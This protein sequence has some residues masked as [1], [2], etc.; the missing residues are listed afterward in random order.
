AIGL[1]CTARGREARP[2]PAPAGGRPHPSPRRHRP[3]S[4]LPPHP[5][6]LRAPDLVVG[7]SGAVRDLAQCAERQGVAGAAVVD[8]GPAAI[9]M[10]VHAARS[11]PGAG[12]DAVA[13]EGR[14][15]LADRNVANLP[16]EP[17]RDHAAS[18][19]TVTTG[20]SM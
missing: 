8:D 19:A 4:R 13:S 2:L 14:N 7:P 6:R 1:R 9:G 5:A 3:A 17:R 20:A 11:L 18:R 15:E 12:D 16:D 10:T